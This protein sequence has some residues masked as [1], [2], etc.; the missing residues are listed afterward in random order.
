M[1]NTNENH[2]EQQESSSSWQLP[3]VVSN[4]RCAK[5]TLHQDMRMAR[6]PDLPTKLPAHQTRTKTEATATSTFPRSSCSAGQKEDDRLQS[7]LTPIRFVNRNI[8]DVSMESTLLISPGDV[9]DS[10]TDDDSSE[11]EFEVP[12]TPNIDTTDGNRGSSFDLASPKYRTPI[13][14]ST[15][16]VERFGE[17]FEIPLRNCATKNDDRESKRNGSF[18]RRHFHSK[19][20]DTQLSSSC[21][22]LDSLPMQPTRRESFKASQPDKYVS[23]SFNGISPMDCCETTSLSDKSPTVPHRKLG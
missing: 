9:D 15:R 12:V 10:E 4:K 5:A 11:E 6:S 14:Y 21:R 1:N 7:P 17:D 13:H 16:S 22:S 18:D 2:H 3:P 19:Q 8:S 20:L 23:R